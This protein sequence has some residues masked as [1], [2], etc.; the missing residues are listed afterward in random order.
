MAMTVVPGAAN[1]TDVNGNPTPG[2]VIPD[3]V[4]FN[5]LDGIDLDGDLKNDVI[6]WRAGD[7]TFNINKKLVPGLYTFKAHLISTAAAVWVKIPG[8]VVPGG[9]KAVD[10]KQN[11]TN[12]SEGRD[13][14]VHFEVKEE[15]SNLAITIH[16]A[17]DYTQ[18]DNK[19]YFI[20]KSTDEGSE[21]GL[22]F[23]EVNFTNALQGLNALIDN[24]VNKVF[25][26][27]ESQLAKQTM[28]A[29]KE[30]VQG[31]I[32]NVSD[33]TYD[34]YV[35]NGFDGNLEESPIFKEATK[36]FNQSTR[37]E[38][39]YQANKL[40]KQMAN[41][42]EASKKDILDENGDPT[43]EKGDVNPYL[44]EMVNKA[45]GDIKKYDDAADKKTGA[46]I[47]ADG[48]VQ[49]GSEA[50]AAE[51]DPKILEEGGF[52]VDPDFP[53]LKNLQQEADRVS[54]LGGY[55][56]IIADS[57][58]IA[59]DSID[60]R[61]ADLKEKFDEMAELYPTDAKKYKEAALAITGYYRTVFN[62]IKA[63]VDAKPIPEMTKD[64]KSDIT[65]RLKKAV[66]E[67][68]SYQ[69]TYIKDFYTLYNNY[70]KALAAVD[71]ANEK[72]ELTDEAEERYGQTTEYLNR[73]QKYD[74]LV[75]AAMQ[76]FKL[77]ELKTPTKEAEYVAV[78]DKDIKEVKKNLKTLADKTI[79]TSD[80]GTVNAA[81]VK[82]FAAYVNG[83]N[84]LDL[85]LTAWEEAKQAG[86]DAYDEEKGGSANDLGYDNKTF[87]KEQFTNYWYEIKNAGKDN[88]SWTA[89]TY[90][91]APG[92]AGAGQ[93][94]D[95]TKYTHDAFL[96]KLKS[97]LEQTW[98][99]FNNNAYT[100]NK[101]T[102]D[103]Y[104]KDDASNFIKTVNA[105]MEQLKVEGNNAYAKRAG[106]N[107][108]AAK[109]LGEKL[110]KVKEA[111]QN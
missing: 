28:N 99:K 93:E 85:A 84:N 30:K 27:Y 44:E 41:A 18:A 87:Y 19:Y 12:A 65:S 59:A 32:T 108:K 97:Q 58:Q 102:L 43:G 80:G 21:S 106:I 53:P 54:K 82:D 38:A 66:I 51:L 46:T 71:G 89:K 7:I 37:I 10:E 16:P 75:K 42:L 17:T 14:E 104:A 81:Y 73:S 6:Q 111:I 24:Y 68:V 77:P 107:A 55:A 110:T 60:V 9:T 79:D 78:K 34:D 105:F 36:L 95:K 22:S 100:A 61:E 35:E 63:E 98:G 109:E 26:V 3:V 57:L 69:A 33:L 13:I 86:I 25:N 96:T 50:A 8:A 83:L 1:A 92:V 74:E 40:K 4:S 101:L 72:P 94:Q 5:D 76:S 45:L 62:A 88:E 64:F 20:G 29:A 52:D 31:M 56:H 91:S 103:T 67:Q 2:A 15:T 48:K 47:G 70:L 90:L 49:G 39:D 11:M 23:D